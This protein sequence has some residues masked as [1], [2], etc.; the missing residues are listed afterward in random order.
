VPSTV[1]PAGLRENTP[2]VHAIVNGTVVT[3][4]GKK[5]VN[6]VVVIRNGVIVAVGPGGEGE[7]SVRVP[8]EA[9][10][11]DVSGKF[12]YPGLIDGYGE[13]AGDAVVA[14]AVTAAA[15]GGG[16]GRVGGAKYWN[17]QV[18]PEFRVGRVYR[19]DRE[20]NRGLRQQGIVARLLA[21]GR[22][23]VKG[24]SAVVDTGTEEGDHSI[25]REDVALHIALAPGFR[26]GG[27][28]S[29]SADEVR[30]PTSPMGAF[31]LVR[32][33][34]YDAQW[35]ERAWRAVR[36]NTLLP[37]PEKNDSLEAL[38]GLMG[39]KVPL[40]V[41]AGDELYALRADRIGDE[42]KLPVIVRGNGQE[43]RLIREIAASG[44]AVVVPVAF[45]R[46]PV[47]GTP[48]QAAGTS[49]MDLMAWDISPENPARLEAAGV[50][51]AVTTSGLSAARGETLLGQMRKAV[52]RGLGEEAALRAMTMTPAR[53]FKVESCLGSIEVGKCASLIV[54]DGELFA[55]K[56]RVMETWVDGERFEIVA[57]APS[58]PRGKWEVVMGEW[59]GQIT[60]GGEPGRL[61]GEVRRAGM[62]GATTE[63]AT[64]PATLPA[65]GP[66]T[67][68]STGPSA[69]PGRRGGGGNELAR[70]SMF[71]SRL[72][73]TVKGELVGAG[74]GVVSVSATLVGERLVGQAML[75]DGSRVEWVGVRVEGPV[76][77]RSATGPATGPTDGPATGP[78]TGATSG[79]TTGPTSGPTSG[80]STKPAMFAANYP[81][82]E[83][84]REAPPEQA[85]AVLFKNATVW[86]GEKEGV[87]ERG[88]VLVENGKISSVFGTDV[89]AE[90]PEGAVVVDCGGKHL[91][92]GI[93]DAHSHMATDGGVNE[94]GQTITA[95]VRIGD[96]IDPTDITIY[97]QL[98]G[99]VTSANILH[100]SAN[101][102]GGQ[103]Q[104]IKLR[105]GAGP[106]EM[107][108]EGAPPG[109][110]FALGENP[111]QSNWG[112]NFTTRYPQS[113]M[114]VE[115]LVRDA[116]LAGRD[117]RAAWAK[118]NANPRSVVPPR[119]DLELE[120]IGEI[121]EKKRWIHSH[122][123]RQ[124]EMLAL[125]RT[126]Q[127]WGLTIGS[128]QHA[129]E[130]YKIADEL[131]KAGVTASGFTDWWAF[132]I[133]VQDA[134]PYSPAMMWKQGVVASLNSD[135]G[136]LGRRMN[137]EAA[138]AM[139][140][141]GVPEHEAWKMVTLNP[142]KSLRIDDKVG[143]IAVGKQADLVVWSGP[144]MSTFSKA[145]QTWIDGRKYW[146]LE[147]D[148]VLRIENR[149]RHAALVQKI[150]GG[151]EEMAGPGDAPPTPLKLW[152][153]HD[154]YCFHAEDGHDL[155]R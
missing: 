140:Y 143:S 99:G 101:T 145:E 28:G 57:V 92:A 54:T 62:G 109:I 49:L 67:G 152:P 89:A 73:F 36:G 41:D 137:T 134:T 33:A 21:P 122:A 70:V 128:F 19:V 105:W 154:E 148:A 113:R 126:T 45:P 151:G 93:I 88:S 31:T 91:T 14:G 118:Y 155:E 2:A 110:K 72:A 46:A 124:D 79:P 74:A 150:L 116:F 80:P 125:L 82:G 142:A 98:A 50:R 71:D 10:V 6:G 86:T 20:V 78:T 147:T 123:Y 47:V 81:L 103:M 37:H 53:L 115:Q 25:V 119:V 66:A 111:K 27:R 24:T 26:A 87:I 1:P 15:G 108:F 5:I 58:D 141:G 90:A 48:E 102:I 59:K 64:L 132:K 106:E 29:E 135:D 30:Y 94:S 23:I 61:T 11:W 39:G 60:V 22:G 40:M 104:V 65:T 51:F 16:G 112:D 129:L 149:K 133:E 100:G 84:G 131:A 114:G 9:R 56:T 68:P 144:P 7:G 138:K 55:E 153:N 77:R 117:Y 83:Y 95:E 32:Q 120:A 146:S 139:K 35:Y 17:P 69:G 3:E 42:F 96:Y 63:P 85:K 52:G 8:V 75:A 107:K 13:W 121:I 12:V 97:R 44:R 4:A 38:A 127:E 130:G 136:E 43:Y 76:T 18:T 34:M